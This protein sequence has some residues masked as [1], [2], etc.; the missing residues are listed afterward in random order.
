MA[1][2][3][4]LLLSLLAGSTSFGACSSHKS[5]PSNTD[6][7]P[8]FTLTTPDIVVAG[9]TEKY[10]CFAKTLDADVAVDRFELAANATIHH[11]FLSRTL[12]PEP[13][14]L[15]ECDVIFKQTWLPMFVT[16]KG[17]TSLEYPSGA[18]SVLHKGTQI[19]LQLHLLNALPNDAHVTGSVKMRISTATNPDPVAIY[20][21]GTQKISLPPLA[22]TDVVDV[23]TPSAD[24]QAFA[25]LAHLHRLGTALHFS[26][27]QDD[28]TMKEVVTRDPYSFDNQFIEQNAILAPKGKKTQITC[29]YNNATK[30]TVTF[31]ES[32]NDE[33]CYLVGYIRGREGAFGCSSR[34]FVP[35]DGGAPDGAPDD[36][37]SD[38]ATKCAPTA[39]SIG[40]GG[41]CTA[42]GNECKSG[43]SCSAD[44][45]SGGGA[46]FC[47]KL[48]CKSTSECG[49]DAT[50]C[51]P[52]QG[53]GIKVC[54]PASCVPSDCVV[55]N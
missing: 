15:S 53:G 6:G 3:R 44:V 23:C 41:P 24:V 5:D 43:L 29:S 10:M 22:K 42:G 34:P 21:F 20:A 45:G 9:G 55:A 18:A 13:E 17:S 32:S 1:Y 8:S 39:N 30:D 26:V 27:E 19:V 47:L 38:A 46:G 2:R 54:L 40:V 50:C 48:G 31:G 28:G 51:A 7:A 37:S 25:T 4:A 16:G 35:D 49:D 33:M 52:S 14:G 36:A 12:A 11:V